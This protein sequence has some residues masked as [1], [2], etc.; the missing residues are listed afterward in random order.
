MKNPNKFSI[1]FFRIDEK[2]IDQHQFSWRDYDEF[3][4]TFPLSISDTHFALSLEFHKNEYLDEKYSTDYFSKFDDENPFQPFDA[5][6]VIVHNTDELPSY[7]GEQILH[8]K[9][10]N[11]DVSIE[12]EVNS[13]DE[14]VREMPIHRRQCYLKHEKSLNFFKIYTKKN[15]EQECLNSQLISRCGCVPFYI[16][17]MDD[18]MSVVQK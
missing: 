1:Y 18:F 12:P 6:R 15:C 9:E 14:D 16:I 3:T 11:S 4:E 2:F 13:I 5:Y 17:S 10:Y 8:V 7:S